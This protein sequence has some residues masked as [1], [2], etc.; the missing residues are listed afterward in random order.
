MIGYQIGRKRDKSRNVFLKK[1]L[2]II[3]CN[4][5]LVVDAFVQ[6][7]LQIRL[8]SSQSPRSNLGFNVLLKGPTAALILLWLHRGSNHKPSGPQ[9]ST[10][11][12]I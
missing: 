3:L 2:I 7:D 11:Q 1:S 5:T 9:S 12:A 8:R 10:S 4:I 6:S